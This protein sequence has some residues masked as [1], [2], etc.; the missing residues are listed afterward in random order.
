MEHALRRIDRLF[1]RYGESHRHRLNK[2]IHW[3]CVPLIMW[4]GLAALWAWTPVAAVT[5]AIVALAFYVWLSPPLALG[6]LGVTAAMLA[7]LPSLAPRALLAVAIVIFVG[8]W[9]GQFVGHR[10]EGRKP[11]FLEDVVFLLVGPAWLLA[12]VYRRLNLRY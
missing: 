5:L 4:S 10:I 9:V 6:M 3:V 11:S 2:A 8:A 7:P 1:E 12:D